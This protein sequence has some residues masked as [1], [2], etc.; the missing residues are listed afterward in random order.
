MLDVDYNAHAADSTDRPVEHIVWLNPPKGRYRFWVEAVDM[1][2]EMK[3][4]PTPFTVWL[5]R[6]GALQEEKHVADI[7]EDDELDVFNFVLV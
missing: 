5:S 2:R 1:D 4:Q 3:G 6:N 7:L